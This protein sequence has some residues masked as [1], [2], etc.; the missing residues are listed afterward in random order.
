MTRYM[1]SMKLQ[2]THVYW[3]MSLFDYLEKKMFSICINLL[4][5]KSLVQWFSAILF[6]YSMKF[7]SLP[8]YQHL[9]SLF[10]RQIFYTFWH[11]WVLWES[12]H[13]WFCNFC[14]TTPF[15]FYSIY[16]PLTKLW[17]TLMIIVYITHI[18][19]NFNNMFQRGLS[20]EQDRINK[21]K[22]YRAS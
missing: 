13:S 9:I 17:Q 15:A 12:I 21:S 8:H 3:P 5:W 7:A 19:L 20:I 6:Y 18:I 16:C 11:V 14:S 10:H 4:H 1:F 22:I 2:D